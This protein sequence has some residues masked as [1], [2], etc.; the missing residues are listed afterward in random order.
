VGVGV[1]VSGR[2]V[3]IGTSGVSNLHIAGGGA[4]HIEKTAKLAVNNTTSISKVYLEST[5][6]ALTLEDG[7]ELAIEV[8]TTPAV[9]AD[10]EPDAEA[11]ADRIIGST[12]SSVIQIPATAPGTPGAPAAISTTV[13]VN[14][15]G[16][17]GTIA[18]EI[19]NKVIAAATAATADST[20]QIKD[21]ANATGAE[22]QALLNG[23]ATRVTYTGTTET[24]SGITIPDGKTLV[25]S[26]EISEQATA[27]ATRG[28]GKLEITGTV[29]TADED[30]TKEILQSLVGAS[31]GGTVVLKGPSGDG[32][33][34]V[35]ASGTPDLVVNL[36]LEI[37]SNA[38]L[39]L[40][41]AGLTINSPGTI[42]NNG[43]ISTT[44]AN[45]P[46]A[47]L[48][49]LL[50]L[51]GGTVEV[52][53]TGSIAVASGTLAI[54]AD[55]TL[56]L[57]GNAELT[58]ATG[59]N[60]TVEDTANLNVA[61]SA[62]LTNNG[63]VNFIAG[64]T[65]E[66]PVEGAIENNNTINTA[67]TNQ[68]TLKALVAATVSATASVPGRVVLNGASATAKAEVTLTEPLTLD[69][70]DLVIGEHAT[71]DLD[72]FTISDYTKVTNGGTI[73]TATTSGETLKNILTAGGKITASAAV[74]GLSGNTTVSTGTT[75]TISTSLALAPGAVLTFVEGA[76]VAP[77]AIT[78]TGATIRVA[79]KTQLE[80]LLP[81]S[82]KVTGGTVETTAAVSLSEGASVTV[83]VGV[84]LNI[85][86]HT[87]TTTGATLVNSGIIKTAVT[88]I[89]LL[90]PILGLG[91]VIEI[92]DFTVDHATNPTTTLTV[93]AS[94]ILT[95]PNNRTLTLGG[96]NAG[97]LVLTD[98]TSKLV[99]LA[100]G[101]VK[102][103]NVGSTI[104]GTGNV[105]SAVKVSA[106]D[107]SSSDAATAVTNTG[108]STNWVLTKGVATSAPVVTV[109]LGKFK[110]VTPENAVLTDKAG[111]TASSNPVPAPGTLK[112][113]A[114]TKITF[115][116]A[117]S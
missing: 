85:G 64:S 31:G 52:L 79:N 101:I 35:D 37:D 53:G 28:T 63:T 71:L 24:L 23:T 75:L 98:A 61:A 12:G 34:S 97:T 58:V 4:L 43:I 117:S 21:D 30:I 8:V 78:A 83:P 76:T 7:A 84:T 92:E 9:D 55:T 109:I 116:G 87:L 6:S 47:D 93:P 86:T 2:T 80:A 36:T 15:T 81:T 66:T 99:L 96:T 1:N 102:A 50:A 40:G 56:K 65:L 68:A 33:H 108:S 45:I 94:T 17:T 112:A 106:V 25:I 19:G 90:N 54:P 3:N 38:T 88:T 46:G 103:A 29:T 113:G 57:S 100:G 105:E 16:Y 42:D 13:S 10:G 74:T 107:T 60:L 48:G 72:T 89:A 51:V 82:A 39:A 114:N 11:E 22:L 91:G 41:T 20:A 115:A 27:I 44:Q 62:T 111:E 73:T 70:Q 18:S 14:A 49:E 26:G 110:L 104:V 95:V 5:N 59:A 77:T 67:T 69:K 32:P